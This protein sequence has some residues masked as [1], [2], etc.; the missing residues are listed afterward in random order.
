MV[1][2]LPLFLLRSVLFPHMPMSLHVFEDRYQEMMRDCLDSGSSFGVVA[3]R[4]GHEVGG[5]AEPRGVGTLARIVHVDRLPDGRMN[6]LITGASRFRVVRPVLGK[7][8]QRAEVEYLQEESEGVTGR[9][10]ASL[11]SAFDGYL[12]SLRRV[13]HGISEVPELPVEP[14]ALAYLVAATLE[15]SVDARQELLEAP[16]AADR[17]RQEIRILRREHDLL[18]RQ[19]L[20]T[21]VV[22]SAFSLN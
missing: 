14:E 1:G 10:L 2:P 4:E 16:D 8:Y 17:I 18:R 13:A 9:L 6:L 20:P 12:G 19:V 21:V 15:T 22:P 7:A 5:D 11:R 3:I